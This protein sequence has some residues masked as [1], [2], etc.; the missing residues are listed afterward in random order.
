M[1]AGRPKKKARNISGLKNQSQT[2]SNIQNHEILTDSDKD[3]CNITHDSCQLNYQSSDETASSLADEVSEWDDIDRESI[4]IGLAKMVL[5]EE[6]SCD[7]EW[8]PPLLKR[9]WKS[10]NT[11]SKS[12]V[13]FGTVMIL[14]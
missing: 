6:E 5:K 2:A 4:S 13:N 12:F 10:E 9:R 1:P 8:L 7:D 11:S 3:F 14:I